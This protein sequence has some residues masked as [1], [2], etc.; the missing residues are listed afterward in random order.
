MKKILIVDDEA[1]IVEEVKAYFE[2]EGYRVETADTGKDGLKYL[3]RMK[4][5][6]LILDVKLPDISG[7]EL[8][9]ISKE[10]SPQTKVIVNTGYVE[11]RIIDESNRLGG[12]A[13]LQKPFDLARLEE[14]ISRLLG[15][16]A[17]DAKSGEGEPPP[18]S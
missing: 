5:D 16:P 14:E 10:T 15:G 17:P 6:I 12:D 2:E 1:G 18:L 13:F 9:R 4:P 8:L 11:Q 7:L 3:K